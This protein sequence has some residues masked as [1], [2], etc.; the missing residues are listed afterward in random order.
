MEVALSVAAEEVAKRKVPIA[1]R[2]ISLISQSIW[3]RSSLS[4]SVVEG[5]VRAS[6]DVLRI[7]H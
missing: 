1:R 5:K 7:V 4:N 3:T 2:R 6:S